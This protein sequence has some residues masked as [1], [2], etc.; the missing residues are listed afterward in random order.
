M[1]KLK[2]TFWKSALLG[3]MFVAAAAAQAHGFKVGELSISHPYARPSLPGVPNSAAWFGVRNDGKEADRVVGVKADI[4]QRA[5][6]HD[7][8]IENDIMR[9]FQVEGVDIPAGQTVTLGDGNK[10]HVMLLGLKNP[11]AVGDRFPLTIQFEKAGAVEVEVWVE[12][13]KKADAAEHGHGAPHQ[14]ES[15]AQ[16]H[17]K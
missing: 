17:A 14:H 8:K 9:M 12:A 3:A 6:I 4:A 15:K 5:E 11:L 7:M 13:P 2:P 10:L 1:L 16:E